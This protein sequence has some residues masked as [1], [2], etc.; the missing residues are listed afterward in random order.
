MPFRLARSATCAEQS[1]EY[2]CDSHFLDAK[3]LIIGCLPHLRM[4]SLY[5]SLLRGTLAKIDDK[6]YMSPVP[7][8]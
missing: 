8:N 5:E 7:R 4:Y 1:A 6:T 3:Q 2:V